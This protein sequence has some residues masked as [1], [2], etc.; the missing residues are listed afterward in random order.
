M[1]MSE[2]STFDLI[3]EF[4]QLSGQ[5]VNWPA[6]WPSEDTIELKLKLIQEEFSELLA[7]IATKE[8]LENTAKEI[9]DFLFVIHGLATSLGINSQACLAEIAESNMSKYSLDKK[10]IEQSV[11][12]LNKENGHGY[13]EIAKAGQYNWFVRRKSDGKVL[14]PISYFPP[15]MSSCIITD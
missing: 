8:S 6:K 3:V 12:K 9:A 14:K 11:A 5:E 7:E 1:I 15:D 13:C 4:N 10:L 2:S